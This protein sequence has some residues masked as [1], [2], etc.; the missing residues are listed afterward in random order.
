VPFALT[1]PEPW[2]NR[3][4]K[5]KIR[6]RE[7]LEP[8]HVTVLYKTSAWRFDLRTEAF[9]D[10]EPSPKDVPE[11]VIGAVRSNLLTPAG[12]GPHVSGEPHLLNGDKARAEGEIPR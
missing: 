4:W 6:D 12:M 11:E 9:L 1:L 8:P 7:R 3:G 2:A 5:A 10:K